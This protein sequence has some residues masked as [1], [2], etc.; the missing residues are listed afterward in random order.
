MLIYKSSTHLMTKNRLKCHPGYT[1]VMLKLY[2]YLCY[3]YSVFK[4]LQFD[5][6]IL[7]I[8]RY[9]ITAE[10]IANY[11]RK[12]EILNILYFTILN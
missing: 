2:Y 1:L 11:K 9:R 4:F 10:V 8:I 7:L 3:F 5:Y 6:W 12:N